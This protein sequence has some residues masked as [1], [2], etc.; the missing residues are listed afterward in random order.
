MDS[1]RAKSDPP[2]SS[3]HPFVKQSFAFRP[4]PICLLSHPSCQ[5]W[6]LEHTQIVGQECQRHIRMRLRV[7]V[8]CERMWRV[9][10]RLDP[11]TVGDR[12]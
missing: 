11:G 10:D 12:D 8:R 3:H 6:H 7:Q 4:L 9:R 2:K 5:S 1:I